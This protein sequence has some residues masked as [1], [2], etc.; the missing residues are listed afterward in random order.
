MEGSEA[1]RV[2]LQE[3]VMEFVNSIAKIVHM[4]VSLHGGS[5]NKNIGDAFLLVWKL[6]RGFTSRDIPRIQDLPKP[7]LVLDSLRSASSQER[8][9]KETGTAEVAGLQKEGYEGARVFNIEASPGWKMASFVD[10]SF[11]TLA[12]WFL[13]LLKPALAR[14]ATTVALMV[15]MILLRFTSLG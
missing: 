8:D 12:G 5:P 7:A 6:P 11:K 15:Y 13:R 2:L 9:P 4:E 10:R 1:G 3:D 14:I